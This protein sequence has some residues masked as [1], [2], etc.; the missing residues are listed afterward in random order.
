MTY[1]VPAK[2]IRERLADY[3]EG[4]L[5]S[6]IS[7]AGLFI[8]GLILLTYLWSEQYFPQDINSSL[9]VSLFSASAIIGLIFFAFICWTLFLPGMIYLVVMGEKTDTRSERLQLKNQRLEGVRSLWESVKGAIRY[10]KQRVFFIIGALL[11]LFALHKSLIENGVDV[12]SFFYFLGCLTASASLILLITCCFWL[13]ERLGSKKNEVVWESVK[14]QG[15]QGLKMLV[16][17]LLS[18]FPLLLILQFAAAYE[19][20]S[21][22]SVK[23]WWLLLEMSLLVVLANWAIVSA[24]QWWIWLLGAVALVFFII[25]MSG[26]WSLIPRGVVR[27][28]SIGDI[29]NATLHL[30]VQGCEIARRY[31]SN[32]LSFDSKKSM[33]MCNLSPVTIAWRI[34]NEYWIKSHSAN[35]TAPKTTKP[36]RL[37]FVP[38]DKEDKAE[39]SINVHV[40]KSKVCKSVASKEDGSKPVTLPVTLDLKPDSKFS[41][42]ASHVVS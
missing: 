25:T 23:V 24:K 30:D 31:T 41:L 16:V 8:G 2:K 15:K 27:A 18:I 3:V 37:S 29:Q 38:V 1:N 10:W 34:G 14:E 26:Q 19:Q 9:I 42:P 36:S 20:T 11:F 21:G 28:L 12:R 22:E 6:S 7:A 17:L 13:F 5:I 4:N 39:C 33:E 35:V 32:D 40:S